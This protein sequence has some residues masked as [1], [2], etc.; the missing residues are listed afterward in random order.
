MGKALCDRR[1]PEQAVI[2]LPLHV[3]HVGGDHVKPLV[4][5]VARDVVALRV[6]QVPVTAEGCDKGGEL[7]ALL[8]EGH[9]VVP[10]PGIS[11]RLVGVLGHRH[12]FEVG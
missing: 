4:V 3:L 1:L 5:G 2:H 12:G 7:A 9:G 10:L 8:V 6:G 11:D